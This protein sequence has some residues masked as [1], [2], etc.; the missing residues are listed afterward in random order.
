MTMVHRS[1]HYSLM[2]SKQSM[3]SSITHQARIISYGLSY[4]PNLSNWKDTIRAD[5][6]KTDTYYPPNTEQSFRAK[7]S[8]PLHSQKRLYQ[9]IPLTNGMARENYQS[10]RRETGSEPNWIMRR[11]DYGS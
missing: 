2:S 8:T 1:S 10:Y 7:T 9:R 5:H 4:N 6:G 11:V 3:D